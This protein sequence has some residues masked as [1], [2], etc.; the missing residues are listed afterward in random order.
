MIRLTVQAK[1]HA[2]T[3]SRMEWMLQVVDEID[4][5]VVA[6]RLCCVGIAAEIGLV[7]A[8]ILGMFAVG[9]A[10]AAGAEISLL[11]TGAIALSLGAALRLRASLAPRPRV[12]GN[13]DPP[14]Q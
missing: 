10:L 9:A 2:Y 1:A 13:G 5:A 6:A 3:H 11:C 14:P 7:M 12:L 4:D 8:G